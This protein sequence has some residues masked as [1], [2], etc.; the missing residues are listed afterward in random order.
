MYSESTLFA[1]NDDKE[2]LHFQPVWDEY[3]WKFKSVKTGKVYNA[4]DFWDPDWTLD[5]PFREEHYQKLLD[6]LQYNMTSVFAEHWLK[7]GLM[8]EAL[9][10]REQ[11]RVVFLGQNLTDDL[12]PKKATKVRKQSEKVYEEEY[13]NFFK[14]FIEEY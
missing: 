12:E 9:Y 7:T 3:E 5:V 13:S 6:A 1:L 2:Y 4:F 11:K 8:Y 10:Y 14:R